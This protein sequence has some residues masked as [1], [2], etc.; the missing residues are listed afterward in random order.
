MYASDHPHDHGDGG[1]RLLAALDDAGRATVLHG[2][3]AAHYGLDV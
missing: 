1:A 2:N 3:A